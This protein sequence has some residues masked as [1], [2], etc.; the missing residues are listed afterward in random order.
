MQGKSFLTLAVLAAIAW[1]LYSLLNDGPKPL[2]QNGGGNFS[3]QDSG[4]NFRSER[5]NARSSAGNDETEPAGAQDFDF[6][7]LS[8]SWSP[9]YCATEGS[10]D[11][12]QCGSE[13]PY[14]FIAHGLWPQHEN[15]YPADCPTGK[16]YV[17]RDLV[18]QMRDIMP[19]GGLMGHEWR[20]HGSCTGLSQA[21][22]FAAV[23]R[24]YEMVNIPVSFR[25]SAQSRAVDPMQVEN[26]FIAA[27][28]RIP[29]GGI[30]VTCQD[31]YLEDV[32]ICM[33]KDLKFRNCGEVDAKACRRRSVTMPPVE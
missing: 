19:S 3:R 8:L 33:T 28:P 32:R 22:Y 21:D 1:F 12:Q 25:N 5:S 29:A 4:A 9:S 18:S 6:Y 17:P 24:A 15:G 31:G 13:R 11:R 16:S 30:A 23:R 14:A 20:K 27:N 2:P 7:V 10:R 26:A